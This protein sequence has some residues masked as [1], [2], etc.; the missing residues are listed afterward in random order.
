MRALILSTIAA[1]VLA[2]GLAPQTASAAWTYQNVTRFDPV[3][4]HCVTYTE[5]VWVPDPVVVVSPPVVVRSP[6]VVSSPVV[7]YPGY[8]YGHYEHD[9]HYYEHEH[10]HH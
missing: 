6:I 10:H 8:H 2:L 5:K 4:Q 7:V 3:C 9:H 1:A